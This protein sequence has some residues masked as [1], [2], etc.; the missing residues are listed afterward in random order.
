MTERDDY[1]WDGSG[2]PDPQVAKLEATLSALRYHGALPELPAVPARSEHGFGQVLLAAAIALFVAGAAFVAGQGKTPPVPGPLAAGWV[3]TRLEGAPRLG[4]GALG[5]QGQLRIGGDWLETDSSSSARIAVADIGTVEVGP[6]SRVRLLASGEREH[7]LELRRGRLEALI[8]APPRL[9]FVDTPSAAAVDLGC[10][11][12][13]LV[14]PSGRGL[15]SVSLGFVSFERDG[16]VSIVPA[17][18]ECETRV[19]VGPG[20]P[21]AQGASDELKAAL[22]DFDFGANS[23]LVG[24]PL[25]TVLSEAGTE[26]ALTL[27]HLLSRVDSAERGQVYDRLVGLVLP[28]GGVTRE[29]LLVLDAEMLDTWRRHLGLGVGW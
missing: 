6:D 10:H 2:E 26:D 21:Y 12:T 3:V 14:E 18:A 9:F 7:R 16:R 15:L 1:L 5:E 19:G 20:T 13:L 29:G 8:T 4:S 28:P 24:N 22:R 27:W 23:K 11:Y 17:D 25:E